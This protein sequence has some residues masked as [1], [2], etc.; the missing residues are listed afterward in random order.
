MILVPPVSFVFAGISGFCGS[1]DHAT[2]FPLPAPEALLPLLL[3]LELELLL[4]EHAVSRRAAAVAATRPRAA[5][6]E[7]IMLRLLNVLGSTEPVW[8]HGPRQATGA[9]W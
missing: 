8:N 5:R 1:L 4:P 9:C 3:L 6:V 7:T 2:T